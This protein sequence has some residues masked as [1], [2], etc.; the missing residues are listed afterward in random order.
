MAITTALAVAGAAE[1]GPH[2]GG[3][4]GAG[5]FHGG[6]GFRVGGGFGGGGFVGHGG[7]QGSPNVGGF[8][9]TGARFLA[10][11][12]V[13]SGSRFYGSGIS[14]GSRFDGG[15]R[16]YGGSR[17]YGSTRVGVGVGVS[18]GRWG[19][20]FGYRSIYGGRDFGRVYYS[21]FDNDRF[22]LTIINRYGYRPFGYGLRYAY[23]PVWFGPYYGIGWGFDLRFG[24]WYG[25]SFWNPGYDWW[26]GPRTV[27]ANGPSAEEL[28][29]RDPALYSWAIEN[30][31][32][33][34]DGELDRWEVR[35][36]AQALLA[37]FDYN[38]DGFLN[39]KEYRYA[40]EYARA[41]PP[42]AFGSRVSAPQTYGGYRDATPPDSRVRTAPPPPLTRAAPPP[43]PSAD[44]PTTPPEEGPYEVLRDKD[45]NP[46]P[47]DPNPPEPPRPLSR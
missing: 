5:G 22:R 37:R 23:S 45:G 4:H 19:G 21:R 26:Y 17:V 7:F 42:P 8:R 28:I 24:Y 12:N 33:N 20:G 41:T 29:L 47:A 46:L 35:D 36:A 11:G 31:D 6:G 43:P 30:Y 18:S 25:S 15:S 16:F 39:A 27:Y 38:R 32:A 10:G 13:T 3:G 40:L 2:G 14:G 44:D 34:G 1:A 9:S